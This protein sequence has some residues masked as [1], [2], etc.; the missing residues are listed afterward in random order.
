[1]LLKFYTYFKNLLKNHFWVLLILVVFISYGQMLWMQPWE[2]DNALFVKLASIEDRVGFFGK[3]P[4]GEGVY[5][6]AAV[7]FILIYKIFGTFIPAYFAL[8]LIL[9]VLATLTVYKVLSKIIGETGGRVVGF[10][11][12]CG[13][14]TSDSFWRMANSATTSISIILIS[15]FT[16]F[17]WQYYKQQKI[18]YYLLSLFFFLIATIIAVSRT[19]YLVAVAIIFEFTLFIFQ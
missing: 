5:R 15:L 17:C 3:G 6:F 4:L 14:I 7:P 16:L 13:Y 10:I 1:M 2:D 9:Y 8:L 11:Y 19:H 12:A 18:K